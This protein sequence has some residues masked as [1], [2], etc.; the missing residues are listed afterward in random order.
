MGRQRAGAFHGRQYRP[1]Y[2]VSRRVGCG[3]WP[4]SPSCLAEGVLQDL[5]LEMGTTSC[6]NDGSIIL[7]MVKGPQSPP[8]PI[9]RAVLS[10]HTGSPPE[11]GGP[12]SAQQEAQGWSLGCII[13]WV[14]PHIHAHFAPLGVVW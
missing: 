12:L 14:D 1:A 5:S 11:A 3:D 2:R 10:I 4:I 7:C 8:N 13:Y 6:T 9:N